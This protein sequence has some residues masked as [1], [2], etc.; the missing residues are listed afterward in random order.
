MQPGH[1]QSGGVQPHRV[2]VKAALHQ[3][4]NQ[5]PQCVNLCHG[6]LTQKRGQ[7]PVCRGL[8]DRARHHQNGVL[9]K[10][11]EIDNVRRDLSGEMVREGVRIRLTFKRGTIVRNEFKCPPGSR[12]SY[13]WRFPPKRGHGQISQGL[14]NKAP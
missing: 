3:H 2:R 14:R 10:I 9:P 1:T 4:T 12:R 13:R 8:H 6:R 7:V 5:N 11:G